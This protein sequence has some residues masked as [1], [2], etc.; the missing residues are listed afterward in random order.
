MQHITITTSPR[1]DPFAEF[2]RAD[3]EVQQ[4]ATAL[5]RAVVRCCRRPA[6]ADDVAIG[7][8]IDVLAL[9]L[10]AQ[11]RLIDEYPDPMAYARLVVGR[12]LVDHDRTE[13]VQQC[14]GARLFTDADGTVQP[15]RTWAYGDAPVGHGGESL[16]DLM[17]SDAD[18]ATEVVDRLDTDRLLDALLDGLDD[19]ERWLLTR[20]DGLGQQINDIAGEYGVVRETLSK[21]LS[22]IRARVQ[23]NRERM[24]TDGVIPTTVTETPA[25]ATAGSARHGRSM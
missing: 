22:K 4:W 10:A 7:V 2:E 17:V 1:T 8:V 9:P 23:I 15:G 25:L 13:R 11:L 19:D 3:R 12:A 20:V 14:R 6:A 16:F 5:V 24:E 18:V 21:R